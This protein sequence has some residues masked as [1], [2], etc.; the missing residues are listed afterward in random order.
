MIEVFDNFFPEQMFDIMVEHSKK[1]WENRGKFIYKDLT[2][3]LYTQVAISFMQMKLG[4][5]V[6]LYRAYSHGHPFGH[7]HYIHKDQN[8]SHTAILFLNKNYQKDWQG[9][10]IVY[11]DKTNYIDFVPNRL[12]IFKADLDHTGTQFQ[13]TT[14]F[15]L[16]NVWKINIE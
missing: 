11:T 15:R 14:N 13:N 1:D 7:H 5:K 2:T 12:I 8:S 3:G 16:Q 9:G 4:K 10:T 6:Q